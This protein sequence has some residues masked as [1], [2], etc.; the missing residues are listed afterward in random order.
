VDD[1]QPRDLFDLRDIRITPHF[2]IL[3]PTRDRSQRVIFLYFAFFYLLFVFR[4]LNSRVGK[5][6][7]PE[8]V[9][10]EFEF[11]KFTWNLQDEIYRCSVELGWLTL[12][13]WLFG[14]CHFAIS[15]FECVRFRQNWRIK[16]DTLRDYR[17]RRRRAALFSRAR[18]A[19]EST[20]R[21]CNYSESATSRLYRKLSRRFRREQRNPQYSIGATV[22]RR[23]RIGKLMGSHVKAAREGL[24]ASKFSP[25]TSRAESGIISRS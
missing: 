4:A 23:A 12:Q 22:S 6:F 7:F 17:R 10:E 20:Y 5:F 24:N 18:R 16:S 2:R 14:C 15:G 11:S 1:S 13:F 21:A 19:S 8:I 25:Q 9:E 3:L